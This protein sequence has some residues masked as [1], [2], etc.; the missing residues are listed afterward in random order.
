MAYQLLNR[1]SY[2]PSE[3]SDVRPGIRQDIFNLEKRC[4]DRADA[5][6]QCINA[7]FKKIVAEVSKAVG[8]AEGRSPTVFENIALTLK[9]NQYLAL[10]R[11][12]GEYG[13]NNLNTDLTATIFPSIQ[14]QWHMGINVEIPTLLSDFFQEIKG[15]L[16]RTIQALGVRSSSN[17]DAVRKSLGVV[18]KEL[19][20]A[21][22]QLI[23][24]RQRKASR[25]WAPSM[26]AQLVPQ[27]AI[28]AAEKGRGMFGRM[29]VRRQYT[30]L[31]S[32]LGSSQ[33]RRL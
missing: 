32:N 33:L 5:L 6:V 28:V 11:R 16:D 12:E 13:P 3:D 18:V 29:K 25:I 22:Q 2:V 20:H 23:T 24:L 21:V 26:K 7:I 9:W 19:S 17:I 14:T 30:H 31:S 4:I 1:A 15:D 10:M 27:Y 8:V